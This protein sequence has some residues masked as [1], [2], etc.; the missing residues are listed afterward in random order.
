MAVSAHERAAVVGPSPVL[1]GQESRR[2]GAQPCRYFCFF[3]QRE[4][5]LLALCQ[6]AACLSTGTRTSHR[7]L[8]LGGLC[9]PCL[10]ACLPV[11][12]CPPAYTSNYAPQPVSESVYQKQRWTESSSRCQWLFARV[13]CS[14]RSS[15]RQATRCLLRRRAEGAL[16]GETLRWTTPRLPLLLVKAGG[17]SQESVTGS[18]LP[19]MRGLSTA[20]PPVGR[21]QMPSSR[22]AGLPCRIDE[23]VVAR[24]RRTCTYMQACLE[25]KGIL[26]AYYAG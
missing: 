13:Y 6:P 22:E 1:C 17:M 25:E 16:A 20:R 10:L 9:A 18:Y 14:T 11:S 5:V 8:P 24:R 21:V 2:N 19:C 23:M 15:G 12:A 4:Q 26:P 7:C 3:R